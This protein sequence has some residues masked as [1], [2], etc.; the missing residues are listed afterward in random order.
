MGVGE[1]DIDRFGAL[2]HG[3]QDAGDLISEPA[4]RGRAWELTSS[5]V[6]RIGRIKTDRRGAGYVRSVVDGEDDLYVRSSRMR[7]AYTGDKVL[8]KVLQPS[9]GD[10]LRDARV[11]EVLE[12]TDRAFRGVYWKGRQGAGSVEPDDPRAPGAIYV[13][14]SAATKKLRDGEIVVVRL[15]PST[16][17]PSPEGK[18]IAALGD[19]DSAESDLASIVAEFDLPGAHDAE[20]IA[21]AE[22]CPAVVDGANWPDRRDLR[23]LCTFTI[24]PTD[25]KDFDDAISIENLGGG[26]VR[27]GVHI[28]DVSHYVRPGSPLDEVAAKRGTSVYLPG[29]VIPM[30]PERISNDLCSLRPEEDRLAKS[31][32]MTFGRTGIV[33]EVEFCR[34]VIHSHRR[35]TYAE[36][37]AILEEIGAE[38]ERSS[39]VDLPEDHEDFQDDLRLL[40]SLRDKL[41]KR[42]QK[43]GALFLDMPAIRVRVDEDG[44]PT[45]IVREERDGSHEL[46]EEFMLAANEAVARYFVEHALPLIGR[47]HPAPHEEKLE[48]F[49]ELLA[50]VGFELHGGTQAS[51]FQKLVDEVVE[52]PMSSA[53]QLAL[54]RTMPHADYVP[55]AAL[56]FALSTDAYCHFTSPIRRYPDLIVHQILEEHLIAEAKGRD[57]TAKR[58]AQWK[59]RVEEVCPAASH[60]ERR[61]EGA[62]RA[63]QQ[64]ALIRYLGPKVGEPMDG[65]IVAVQPFG[66]IVRVEPLHVEGIVHVSTLETYFEFDREAQALVPAGSGRGRR[67]H[68][69]R[70]RGGKKERRARERRAKDERELYTL[71][72]KVRVELSGLDPA[73]R[74]IHFRLV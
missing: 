10:R 61:A 73:A 52:T 19:G 43:R 62:E 21:E 24:D 58:L 6:F 1:D 42:R 41:H 69:R 45:G 66:F 60:T 54:L 74:E 15:M 28:A 8:V 56:H 26:K 29:T 40:A 67:G 7:D 34:S 25:A 72:Q 9:R 23:D 33:H 44:E 39:E 32:F 20:T 63:M 46:I 49:R 4:T 47:S 30:L 27:L 12:R 70:G 71:G 35:F 11:V 3:L 31:A 38:P 14:K 50:A 13:P 17:A 59:S 22:R 48:D 57:L 53:V 55:G 36:V 68:D 51:D 64:L 2:V 37:Q 16:G 65:W 5:S 18:I